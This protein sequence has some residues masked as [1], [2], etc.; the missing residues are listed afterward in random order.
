MNTSLS[1]TNQARSQWRRQDPSRPRGTAT[2]AP[3]DSTQPENA[4]TYTNNYDECQ[5]LYD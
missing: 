3:V 4:K 5:L 2:E 1:L